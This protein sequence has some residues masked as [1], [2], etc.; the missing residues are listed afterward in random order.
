MWY[1]NQDN[2]DTNLISQK[3]VTEVLGVDVQASPNLI[4]LEYNEGTL[5]TIGHVDL[6]WSPRHQS[7]RRESQNVYST[8]FHVTALYDPPFDML[9]GRRVVVECGMVQQ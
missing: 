2:E 5:E 1:P 7:R 3:L 6:E 8:R 4:T 9:V